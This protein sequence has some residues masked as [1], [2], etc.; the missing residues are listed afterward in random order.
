M[1]HLMQAAR[2]RAFRG[3]TPAEEEEVSVKIRSPMG[4]APA[5]ALA[6]AWAL[7]IAPA[8]GDRAREESADE[9][10][11]IAGPLS[12][13]EPLGKADSIG[14]PGPKVNSD[15][16]A[17]QVWLAA[18]R[19]QDTDTPAARAA[20]IAWAAE[21][22]LDWDGKYARW[23]E[24]LAR[25]AAHDASH[26]TF[27]LTTPWGKV[28]PAPK[29][30]CAEL[31]IFLRATFAAWYKLPFYL[32]ARDAEGTR[33]FFGHF[34]ARTLW[35]RYKKTP[36]FALLYQDHSALS[37]GEIEESG[38]PSDDKLR[39]KGLAGKG[40]EQPFLGEGAR[41]GAYFDEIHLN[42]RVGHFL[43]L[44]LDSFGSMHLADSRNTFN[45]TPEAV[46][47]GDVLVQ[48]W[49]RKGIGHALLVKEVVALEDGRIGAEL[50]SGSMPRRQP[51]WES[52]VASKGYFT[53][54]YAGGEGKN[55]AG[56]A[57]AK[58]GGGLKRFRVTK[59]LS[60]RWTN[61]WMSAD[62]ASWIDDKDHAR[63]AARPA[64]F[65]ALLGEVDPEKL[66]AALLAI[67]DDA[68]KHLGD[69][70]ASCAARTKREDAFAELY[71]LGAD[72]FAETRAHIDAQHRALED[73]V[74]AE[75]DYPKSKTCCWNS[76]TPA[77]Y[78]I[79]MGYNA[80]GMAA[81]CAEPVVF[82]ARGG[83]Y[84]I[85]AQYAAATG[86]AHLWKSWSE[87]E[88]CPQRNVAEDTELGSDATPWCA[89]ESP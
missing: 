84:Q 73:Y 68:R 86:R 39:K 82:K 19:W 59:N 37:A 23:I 47:E 56:E 66:R 87:D 20:G 13:G 22:G 53:S 60:G 75:L 63:I 74:F 27:V 50:A 55:G 29:L 78:E 71:Q 70:P 58:L 54:P 62:E 26:D 10:Y 7:G 41:S 18:N 72:V 12:P 79:V 14:V 35:G 31:A 34:G 61:T 57:Y 52:E 85:F 40:D 30:E 49:Q 67:I 21:S 17:T 89:L 25:T 81:S 46:R 16:S 48:R 65:D 77:M 11:E 6:L 32:E 88:P 69:Y 76:T 43:V 64:A 2:R 8:C 38:W 36:R 42:K 15:T 83:G 24:S 5:F 33:V 80:A 3:G 4:G 51:K 28:L 9:D 44:L 1:A 45:L